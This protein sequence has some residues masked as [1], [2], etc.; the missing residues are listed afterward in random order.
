[1]NLYLFNLIH[2]LSGRWWLSDFAAIFFAEY[3]G[4][5]LILAAIILILKEK[6]IRSRI[7]FF[8]FIL[9]V[10][11]LSKGIIADIIKFFYHQP[12]PYALLDFKPLIEADGANMSFPSGH[13][14]FFFAL[15]L[16]IFFLNRKAGYWFFGGAVLMGIARIFTG[17]HW[18]ADILV[19]ALIG[20]ASGFLIKK[21][22]SSIDK[23]IDKV[24]ESK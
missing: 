13:A 24:N 18:P 2:D 23:N 5:F 16:P 19:G 4:Y 15:A 11:I 17:V 14:A 6:N 21:I 7:Y 22:L 12:R 20:L 8:S 1:M 9:F 3:L 10:S